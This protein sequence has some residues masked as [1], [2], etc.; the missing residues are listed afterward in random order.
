[1]YG[2]GFDTGVRDTGRFASCGQN[3]VPIYQSARF[4]NAIQREVGTRAASVATNLFA[5]APIGSRYVY[6]STANFNTD[7]SKI[8]YETISI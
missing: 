7:V 3:G 6:S 5:V 2:F 1:M 4:Q 8:V